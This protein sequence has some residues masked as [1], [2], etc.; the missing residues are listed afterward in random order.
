MRIAIVAVGTQ[1]DIQPAVV[2]GAA[3]K[4]AGHDVRF[5]SAAYYHDFARANGL[6]PVSL[7]SGDPRKIMA[8]VQ[9]ETVAVSRLRRYLR[10]LQPTGAPSADQKSRIVESCRG[11]DLVL[12]NYPLIR[13]PVEHLRLR[14]I[15]FG[16]TPIHP[17]RDFPH[18]LSRLGKSYGGWVNLA[19]HR[20]VQMLFW[21]RERKWLNEW[22]RHLGLAP[23]TFSRWQRRLGETPFLYGI[24]PTVLPPPADWPSSI[25]VTGYW[26]PSVTD[27][28][29]PAPG[30][31]NFLNAGSPPI[32]VG[33]GSLV[34][35]DA[36]GLR[37]ILM[38]ALRKAGVR[39]LILG[40]WGQES[41][42]GDGQDIFS[43]DWVPYPWLLPKVSA[44]VH[45]AGSGTCAQALLAG[46]PSVCVAFSGEQW[47]WAG[48]LVS[49]K[50]C[51]DR[52]SRREMTA[53]RLAESIRRAHT[54]A[55]LRAAAKR[56]GEIIRH[57]N[58]VA[59]AVAAIEEFA[60]G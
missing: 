17:S 31:V 49:L 12:A 40:G 47:F 30:L 44:L 35:P 58:G 11:A 39:G 7:N 16:V 32:A 60:A 14:Y 23:E 38:A 52:I 8:D 53:E 56:L 45:H 9:A 46:V 51:A 42:S 29:Q 26:F 59:L 43:T 15:G 13:H 57:E 18:P 27:Q 37:Q 20:A 24:S 21:N 1:G 2:L 5:A 10:I 25:R 4:S 6:E 55:T 34:D 54:D 28:W 3:L 33:F 41:N 50:A 22:R 19:T 48:R 36:A